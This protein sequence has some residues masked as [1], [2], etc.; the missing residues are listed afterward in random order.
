MKHQKCKF[1][2]YDSPIIL[3]SVPLKML[4]ACFLSCVLGITLMAVLSH[5]L[6]MA[7]LI[8]V[9]ICLCI[10]TTLLT[11]GKINTDTACLAP[12]LLLCLV[13]TPASWFTFDGLLG[14]TPYLS[15]LFITIIT[16]TYYRRIQALLLS[17][18][19]ALML[20]L[21]IHWFITWT[22]K[23]DIEHI[24]NILVAYFLTAIL[25]CFFIEK[26]KRKNLEL[27]RHIMDLSLRDDLTG[28]LNRRA[29]EQVINRME[30][31]FKKE[32][33]DYAVAMLDVDKFKH[34]NDRF[35][36]ALGD[37][38][39][40][41]IAVS[42]SKSVRS[43]DYAFRFGGDEFLLILPNMNRETSDK[44]CKR[45]E[46]CLHNIQGYSFPVNVSKGCALRSECTSVAEI[47]SLADQ[48]MYEVK[49]AQVKNL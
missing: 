28:L 20:G 34:I 10:T 29:I 1:K 23:L 21:T 47:L 42:I 33:T 13:Y 25:N 18:Y 43:E 44:I 49:R 24:S 19:G 4:I 6:L 15:I 2:D 36:H 40:K 8:C 9:I 38:V 31:D 16:L 11:V 27:N 37:S 7:V 12:I 46:E 35:G 22:D 41:N 3:N 17:V 30:H 39:L 48:R 32:E 26:V 5:Y 45:I 14:C